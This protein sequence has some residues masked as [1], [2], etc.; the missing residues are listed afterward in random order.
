M[1]FSLL[2]LGLLQ[3]LKVSV[4]IN[5]S[6]KKHIRNTHVRILFKT[7]DNSQGRL[8]V[9][10]RGKIKSRSGADHAFDVALV[11]KDG[12]TGFKVLSSQKNDAVF[13]AAASGDMHLEGMS[14]WAIWFQES[15]K[16]LTP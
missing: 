7:R 14:A 1:R 15:M 4:I 6:F 9:F 10:D 13:N 3:A 8:I 2:L 16:L 5:K 11:F 12:P